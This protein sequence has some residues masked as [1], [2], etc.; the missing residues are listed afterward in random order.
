MH[1]LP[2]YYTTTRYGKKSKKRKLTKRMAKINQEHEKF[3]KKM[4][5]KNV[6][7]SGK[8]TERIANPSY[9]GSNPVIHSI[10]TSDIIPDNGN[11][12]EQQ[13]YTGTN[14]LGIATMHKSNMVPITNKQAA[15]D[16]AKMRRA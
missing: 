13:K 16:I 5:V 8:A 6:D 15:K 10:P 1:L 2:V 12:K 14:I 11:K 9:A 4:G 7:V 3:L